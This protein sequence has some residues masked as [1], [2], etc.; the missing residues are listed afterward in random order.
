MGKTWTDWYDCTESRMS[1]YNVVGRER[2]QERFF[3]ILMPEV[4]FKE[5]MELGK[6][7][8]SIGDYKQG[9][10]CTWKSIKVAKLQAAQCS[11]AR[12]RMA[13]KQQE[14]WARTHRVSHGYH[15]R[16]SAVYSRHQEKPLEVLTRGWHSPIC[17]QEQS[18]RPQDSW[19]ASY[20]RISRRWA[21]RME[22]CWESRGS[23]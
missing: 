9:E 21:P 1:K 23:A 22:L 5:K 2:D 15:S 17:V 10:S 14:E 18:W 19:E 16:V 12:H 4:R 3:E 11:K 20:K 7:E 8:I 6:W 13:E